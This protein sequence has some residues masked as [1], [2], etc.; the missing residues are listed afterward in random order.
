MLF[1]FSATFFLSQH[2][3]ALGMCVFVSVRILQARVSWEKLIELKD[4]VIRCESAVLC[5]HVSSVFVHLC[6][7]VS[8][9]V[10]V[11]VHLWVHGLMWCAHMQNCNGPSV[12]IDVQI[13]TYANLLSYIFVCVCFFWPAHVVYLQ[14]FLP[15]CVCNLCISIY[16]H[17]CMCAC[18]P[19]IWLTLRALHPGVSTVRAVG[20]VFHPC[21]CLW[22]VHNAFLTR[23]IS[24]HFS[25]RVRNVVQ[26]SVASG[27]DGQTM[28]HLLS[29]T[30]THICRVSHKVSEMTLEKS[31][32]Q[33]SS[34]F[35]SMLAILNS[36]SKSICKWHH[37]VT[38]CPH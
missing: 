14:V 30:H 36:M 8:L 17:I 6:M 10:Y 9:R 32:R 1:I 2:I 20:F 3:L 35:T 13:C 33:L 21:I 26:P 7:P 38:C 18:A 16:R 34:I 15:V 4:V 29:H 37:I 12:L 11:F 23:K 28:R 31:W 24:L 5:V 27:Q 25:S 19:V 22:W